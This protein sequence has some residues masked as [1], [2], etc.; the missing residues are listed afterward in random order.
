MRRG[1]NRPIE[2]EW[3][4]RVDSGVIRNVLRGTVCRPDGPE[5]YTAGRGRGSR[6]HR[7]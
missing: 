7:G 3:E 4:S 1:R 6:L 5:G 2:D